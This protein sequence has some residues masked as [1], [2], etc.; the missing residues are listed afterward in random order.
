MLFIVSICPTNGYFEPVFTPQSEE[1]CQWIHEKMDKCI[2]MDRLSLFENK[3]NKCVSM[4]EGMNSKMVR[5]F[6]KMAAIEN[7]NEKLINANNQLEKKLIEVNELLM[8]NFRYIEERLE[9]VYTKLE[10]ES[11]DHRYQNDQGKLKWSF[12][13][14]SV[15]CNKHCDNCKRVNCYFVTKIIKKSI[16]E[17]NFPFLKLKNRSLEVSLLTSFSHLLSRILNCGN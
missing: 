9:S 4:E 12:V 8:V 3:I 16:R 11:K 14:N 17:I 6:N 13:I 5:L 7:N 10:S 15:P 1:S 2:A